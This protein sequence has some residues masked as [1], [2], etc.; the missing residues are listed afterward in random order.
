MPE[1]LPAEIVTEK[2]KLSQESAWLWLLDIEITDYGTLRFVNNNENIS[3]GGNTY[4]KCNF[5]MGSFNRMESQKLSEVTLDISNADLI[6]YILPYVDDYDGL[7]GE[8]ITRTPVNSK[9]LNLDMSS[10]AEEFIITGCSAGEQ[11]IAF[12]LGA[13]NPLNKRLPKY[14]YF[15]MYCRYVKH[16]KDVECGYSGADTSCNGTP[17]DCIS[18]NNF[19]RFGGQLG[20]RSKSVKFV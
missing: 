20:L 11:W 9:Y 6:N 2:N 17:E 7:I 15:G 19:E 1:D 16:F 8:T 13:A 14:R 10:K 5:N 18:K 12:V 3:Y 4:Y